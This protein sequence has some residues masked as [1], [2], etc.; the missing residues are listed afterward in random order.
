MRIW[1]TA[2]AAT[3]QQPP[4]LQNGEGEAAEMPLPV[5]EP[6]GKAN[7]IDGVA[8]QTRRSKRGVHKEDPMLL[9][10]IGQGQPQMPLCRH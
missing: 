6:P 1:F 4:E 3:A 2:G 9:L 7:R 8:E 10:H 5:Y